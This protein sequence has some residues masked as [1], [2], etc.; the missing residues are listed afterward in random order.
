MGR[1]VRIA[2]VVHRI[3]IVRLVYI[4]DDGA[5]GVGRH[6]TRADRWSQRQLARLRAQAARGR[7]LVLANLIRLIA[8]Q[9]PIV[10]PV[11]RGVALRVIDDRLGHVRRR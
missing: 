10:G 1:A 3:H 6:T 9:R 7:L 8:H 11:E 4:V 2:Q 5:A